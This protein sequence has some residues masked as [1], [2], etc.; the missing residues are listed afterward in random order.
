MTEVFLPVPANQAKY[1]EILD[2][3]TVPAELAAAFASVLETMKAGQ[4][5]SVTALDTKLSTQQ[6]ADFLGISRR[7]FIAATVDQGVSFEMVGSHRRILLND[8][9][10]M[11][12]RKLAEQK[13]LLNEIISANVAAGV[14]EFDAQMMPARA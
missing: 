4:A 8:L 14:Y 7:A 5:V 6:A 3:L 13:R 10:A 1:A 2:A 11:Q 9:L 12:T